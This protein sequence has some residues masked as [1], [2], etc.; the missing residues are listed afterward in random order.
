MQNN[1]YCVDIHFN[2]FFRLITNI[3]FFLG[4]KS[5][6]FFEKRYTVDKY[7]ALNLVHIDNKGK[8]IN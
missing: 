2:V 3:P 7:V 8:V 4:K 5:K 6:T 1:I